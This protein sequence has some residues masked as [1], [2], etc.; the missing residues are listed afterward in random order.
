VQS[1]AADRL[2]DYLVINN[3]QHRFLHKTNVDLEQTSRTAGFIGQQQK[4]F[5]NSKL[6]ELNIY[7]MLTSYNVSPFLPSVTISAA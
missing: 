1:T 7:E 5:A 3:L 4:R 6:H 2:T